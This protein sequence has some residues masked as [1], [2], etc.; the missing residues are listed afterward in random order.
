VH[1]ADPLGSLD[2]GRDRR[3]RERGRVGRQH[4]LAAAGRGQPR[5]DLALQ[6]ERLRR[7][8]DDEVAAGEV[9]EPW[10]GDQAGRSR[11]RLGRRPATALGPLDQPGAQSL[12]AG[13]ER[14]VVGVVQERLVAAEAGELGDTG[15]HRAGPGDAD[16]LDLH[17]GA[18]S[19]GVG[20]PSR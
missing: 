9:L 11:L 7:R 1:A 5:E 12:R 6:L 2:L 18:V 19:L 3:H 13:G 17:F 20:S 10:R 4:R 16:A 15:A 8:F 14:L